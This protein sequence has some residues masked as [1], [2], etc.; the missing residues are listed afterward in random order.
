MKSSLLAA[1]VLLLSA[2]VFRLPIRFALTE[3][4]SKKK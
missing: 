2:V 4:P 3:R 1:M